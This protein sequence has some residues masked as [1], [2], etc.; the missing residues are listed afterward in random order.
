[1]L[2]SLGVGGTTKRADPGGRWFIQDVS[3]SRSSTLQVGT[4]EHIW[5]R[6]FN[7]ETYEADMIH[8]DG[9]TLWILGLKTEGRTTHMLAENGAKVEVLGGVSYQSWGKQKFD[10]PMFIVKDAEASF[11]YG[12]Y[13]TGTP[14]KK[15]VQETRDGVTRTLEAKDVAGFFLSLYRSGGEAGVE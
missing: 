7:P 6:Q 13:Q 9:G 14:F 4:D 1:M 12:L 5:A 2:R 3:P 10:P 8:V 11:T 15:I